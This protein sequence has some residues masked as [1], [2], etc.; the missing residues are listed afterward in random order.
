MNLKIISLLIT[1]LFCSINPFFGQELNFYSS[2]N[3]SFMLDKLDVFGKVLYIAAHP[4]DE[5]TRLI[6]YLANERKY[7]TGYL[8]ATRGGGGQNFLGTHLKENLGVIR[9]QELLEARK[10]D[11]G[12]QF[13]S[14]ALDFGY[15]KGPVET[16]KFWNE[17]KILSDFVWIIR[18]FRPD[19]LITRFNQTPGITH[20]HHTS[21]AILANKAFNLSGDPD[22]FPE[23]LE[24]VK[25]WKPK[26]IMWNTSSFFTN[27]NELDESEM[28]KLD[29]GVYNSKIG[30]SYN[31]LASES[32]SMHKSQAFGSLRRRGSEIEY[33]IYSQGNKSTNDLMEDIET[34]WERVNPSETLLNHIKKAQD[35]FNINYPYKIIDDLSLAY[36]ELNRLVDRDWREIKKNEIKNLIKASSGLFF[37]SLSNVDLASSGNEITINFDVINRSPYLIKLEKIEIFDNEYIIG[38]TLDNNILLSLNKKV[39]IPDF[40]TFSEKYWLREKPNFGS[41]NIENLLDVGNADNEPSILSKFTFRINNQLISYLSPVVF[42]KNNPVKGDDYKP[43]VIGNPIYINPKNKLE[44][45]VN[46]NKKKI[47]LEIISGVNNMS[48]RIY[49]YVDENIK[50]EPEYVDVNLKNKN[51]KVDISFEVTL[52][53]G[54]KTDNN[55]SFFSDIDGIKYSRGIELVNYDHISP[56]TRFP[57]SEIKII[58]FNLNIKSNKIGYIM[59]SGDKIPEALSTVGYEVDLL[60]KDDI[61]IEKISNYDAIILGIRAYNSDNSLYEIKPILIEFMSKG[62]NVIVQYNTSRN[63]DTDNFAP[64]PFTLS[65]NRVSQE[66]APV[67]I[68]NKEHRALSYPNKISQNDF[69]GWVQERGLYFPDSWS[70]KYEVIISSNDQGETA[71]KGG[72]L[73]SK[74]GKGHFVYTS[75]SWFRQ[76]PS[77]VSGAYRLFSNLIS[78]GK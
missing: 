65:R 46:T 35:S 7:E 70:E 1:S 3:I 6:T 61:S 77:G 15:S 68:L 38:D 54:V 52:L 49:P 19:I 14:S 45:F 71:N 30:K 51:D 42:K 43:F 56:Q 22:A 55:I 29:V 20:G 44:L 26:R 41:Y 53:N 31:E 36:K 21:S 69:D 25:V 59:G 47:D 60:E 28:I 63:L 34:S 2:S 73:I 11:G 75:Y 23:Q 67:T 40:L 39:I 16:L 76:L 74:V 24:Y 27:I 64:Y 10:I 62:G 72:I 48:A 33:L 13:F 57:S 32:R 50:V 58:D 9:T 12:K 8:S 4:D 17:E 5:N 66:D 18:K 78:L 37:E